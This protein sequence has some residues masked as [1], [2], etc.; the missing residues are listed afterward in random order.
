ML[1]GSFLHSYFSQQVWKKFRSFPC[2]WGN[3]S[4]FMEDDSSS[5]VDARV[6]ILALPPETLMASDRLLACFLVLKLGMIIPHGVVSSFHKKYMRSTHT[7]A[8]HLQLG[9]YQAFCVGKLLCYKTN[10]DLPQFAELE[11]D[12]T[13]IQTQILLTSK[14]GTLCYTALCQ[15]WQNAWKESE[16]IKETLKDPTILRI[17]I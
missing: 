13:R 14:L 9:Q 7:N 4:A 2:F 16:V 6:W 3:S 12:R 5:R 15:S 8:R 1:E 10:Y 11:S 17:C